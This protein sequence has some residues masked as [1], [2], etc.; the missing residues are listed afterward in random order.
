MLMLDYDFVVV[1]LSKEDKILLE[2]HCERN[3]IAIY[4]YCQKV[5]LDA[6]RSRK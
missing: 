1:L 6:L 4:E 2:N 5:I 3:N